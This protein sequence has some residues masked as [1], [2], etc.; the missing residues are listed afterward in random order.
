MSTERTVNEKTQAEFDD[1]YITSKELMT[2]LKISKATLLLGNKRGLLPE[3][4][5]VSGISA[6]L[7]VRAE[8]VELVDAWDKMLTAKRNHTL[9][10]SETRKNALRDYA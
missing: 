3:P 10:E 4:L 8:T 6:Y 9:K 7:W 1:K 5:T 2:R